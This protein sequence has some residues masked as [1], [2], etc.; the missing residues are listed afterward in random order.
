MK[1][2]FEVDTFDGLGQ[3]QVLTVV[4]KDETE[5]REIFRR[6]YRDW[7]LLGINKTDKIVVKNLMSGA[8][9]M[10][11]ED[12]PWCCNPASETYWSM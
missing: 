7:P 6:V 4:A 2:V 10:I 8:D 3:G 12:T 11:P 5:A 9:V 1:K